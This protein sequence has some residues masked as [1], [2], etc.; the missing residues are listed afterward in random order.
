MCLPSPPGGQERKKRKRSK[1]LF[2]LVVV[3]R[4]ANFD[5]RVGRPAG[6]V[7]RL[8]GGGVSFTAFKEQKMEKRK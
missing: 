4:L 7:A 6:N 5:F 2:T 3:R 1:T 8:H